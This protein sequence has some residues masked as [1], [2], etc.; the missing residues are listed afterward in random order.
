MNQKS[1]VEKT[2]SDI[3]R[4]TRKRYSAEKKIRIALE[5]LRG[6]E[7]IAELCCPGQRRSCHP[8][9][10]GY[11]GRRRCSAQAARTGMAVH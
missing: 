2:V 9:L 8:R 11:A 1:S 7:S 10:S 6:E 3:R 4:A 5:G